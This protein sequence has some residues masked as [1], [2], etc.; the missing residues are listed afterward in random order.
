MWNLGFLFSFFFFFTMYSACREIWT[1]WHKSA[2]FQ[3]QLPKHENL[4]RAHNWPIYSSSVCGIGWFIMKLDSYNELERFRPM[5]FVKI[6]QILNKG[7]TCKPWF[8][9]YCWLKYWIF[10][11][12]N[13][14]RLLWFVPLFN[15]WRF[16]C[17]KPA[18]F[19]T[20]SRDGSYH[21]Q[22]LFNLISQV[23]WIKSLFRI[24]G[25]WSES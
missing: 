3:S 21:S 2:D 16:R 8:C 20:L 23:L 24:L 9:F 25:C 17:R 10:Q 22:Y 19:T 5:S 7:S 1:R 6:Y 18:T 14:F 12:Q 15:Q 4:S 13:I 11:D